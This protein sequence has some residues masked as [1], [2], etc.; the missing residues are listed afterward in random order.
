MNIQSNNKI[1][2][3][4]ISDDSF[5]NTPM[6]L[7]LNIL[8]FI[9]YIKIP[10]FQQVCKKYNNY[11]INNLNKY[12]W[13][14]VNT[15]IGEYRGNML[16][17]GKNFKGEP[18]NERIRNKDGQETANVVS[19]IGAL[20]LNYKSLGGST[21]LYKLTDSDCEILA[22]ALSKLTSLYEIHLDNNNITEKG[23]IALAFSLSKLTTLEFLWINNNPFKHKGIKTLSQGIIHMK[24]LSI[25]NL[26]YTQIG[27]EGCKYL[28]NVFKHLP[29]LIELNIGYNQIGD[30]GCKYLKEGLN[31]KHDKL[32][33]LLLSGNQ[34]GDDGCKYLQ[35]GLI[36]K[37]L[38]KLWMYHNIF[39]E[40]G[41]LELQKI[42]SPVKFQAPIYL[43]QNEWDKLNGING[44]YT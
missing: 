38:T 20:Y 29:N 30:E 34:I 35:E 44:L 6:D 4:N 12:Y 8:N 17:Q 23:C 32:Q 25:L 3:W 18:Q 39:T 21:Q 41:L 13:P 5:Q 28:I 31:Y 40:I 2:E 19:Y 9:S 37:K 42:E 1:Y 7:Q 33:R 36:N 10:N 26:N 15:I 14:R 22:L 43:H 11:L 16:K 24:S 27:V